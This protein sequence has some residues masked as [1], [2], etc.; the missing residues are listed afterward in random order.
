MNNQ[1]LVDKI[2]KLVNEKTN[3][4]ELGEQVRKLIY[5]EKIVNKK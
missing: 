2:V 4:Y 5:E 3:N 1:E